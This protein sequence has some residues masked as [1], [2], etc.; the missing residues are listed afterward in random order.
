MNI[1]NIE[2][3]KNS[4]SVAGTIVQLPN[5]SYVEYVYVRPAVSHTWNTWIWRL[6]LFIFQ[7]QYKRTLRLCV[8]LFLN[9]LRYVFIMCIFS[10][11]NKVN[12][13]S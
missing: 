13:Y 5:K 11:H 8:H 9:F 4:E 6:S 10:M 2:K 12:K 7:V 1:L 3:K